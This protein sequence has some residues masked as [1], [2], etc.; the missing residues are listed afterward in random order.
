MV[1]VLE[2]DM[3]E[4]LDEEEIVA[5]DTSDEPQ[6]VESETTLEEEIPEIAAET[7]DTVPVIHT[8]EDEV[9][10]DTPV[11]EAQEEE[12]EEPQGGLEVAAWDLFSQAIEPEEEEIELV[13]VDEV[14]EE[15][16]APVTVPEVA[17]EF[18]APAQRLWSAHK[19]WWNSK[20]R[21]MLHSKNLCRKPSKNKHQP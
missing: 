21:R 15:P 3:E 16:E 11:L 4:E 1:H 2:W 20:N 6:L 7:E 13:I 18:E 12:T 10:E 8:L 5:E 19:A 17:A 14:E 9:E